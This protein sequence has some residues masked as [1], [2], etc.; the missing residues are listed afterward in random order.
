LTFPTAG[1]DAPAKLKLIIVFMNV[2]TFNP[3]VE[4]KGVEP[5]TSRMQI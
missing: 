1:R 4:N 2:A 3:P 5:L